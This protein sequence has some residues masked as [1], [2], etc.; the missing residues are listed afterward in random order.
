MLRALRR[1]AA[2][3]MLGGLGLGLT[4]LPASADTVNGILEAP[5]GYEH[6]VGFDHDS[7][8]TPANVNPYTGTTY[9]PDLYVN[10]VSDCL[11]G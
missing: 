1:A 7:S 8:H 3:A 6:C 4:A 10:S 9:Y 5:N 11:G 2:V